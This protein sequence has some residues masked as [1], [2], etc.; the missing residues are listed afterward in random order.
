MPSFQSH[1]VN[2]PIPSPGAEPSPRASLG[3]LVWLAMSTGERPPPA[4]RG[5]L[6]VPS[7][8]VADVHGTAFYTVSAVDK[9][10]RLSD[11]SAPLKLGWRP[12]TSVAIVVRDKIVVAA[13]NSNGSCRVTGQA[14]LR[15][16]AAIRRAAHIA[17]G[18][19]LLVAA[20]CDRELLIVYPMPIL[21]A[22][23]SA[24]HHPPNAGV[25]Q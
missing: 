5:G 3:D 19:R 23:V 6:P 25:V 4:V 2:S 12:G 9:W 1:L 11:R 14:H 16:P 8:P 10:G 13:A 7:L 24:F 17:A 15:L 22:M 21:D 20:C 18:D